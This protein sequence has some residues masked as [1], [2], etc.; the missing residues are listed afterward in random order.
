MEAPR[1]PNQPPNWSKG[2]FKISQGCASCFLV[3]GKRWREEFARVVCRGGM[4]GRLGEREEGWMDVIAEGGMIGG[5]GGDGGGRGDGEGEGEKEGEGGS[6]EGK[7]EEEG[8]QWKAMALEEAV[9]TVIALGGEEGRFKGKVSSAYFREY[10]E[11][12]G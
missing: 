12:E 9:R 7:G 4:L 2:L 8:W 1:M 5:D 3:V 11:G 6:A 10:Y